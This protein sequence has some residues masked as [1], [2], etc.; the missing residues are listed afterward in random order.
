MNNV[1]GVPNLNTGDAA[2]TVPDFAMADDPGESLVVL[3]RNFI[4]AL[5]DI[6]NPTC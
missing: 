6:E 2:T 5:E 3:H 1:A 4:I